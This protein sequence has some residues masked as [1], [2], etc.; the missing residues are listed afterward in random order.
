MTEYDFLMQLEKRIDKIK[1]TFL[2]KGEEYRRNDDCLHNFKEG[3]KITGKPQ[4]S[5]L[6]GFLLKHLISYFDIINDLENGI[7]TKPE[8]IDEKI[9]DIINY[10][11]IQEMIL[12]SKK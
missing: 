6:N 4:A 10:F 11:I 8:L 12:K 2:L 1:E 9:G 7:E 5:V 3:A